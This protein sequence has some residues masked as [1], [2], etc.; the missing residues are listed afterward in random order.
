[1]VS[2][3]LPP[4]TPIQPFYM[5]VIKVKAVVADIEFI[6]IH[7]QPFNFEPLSTTYGG[8][9]LSNYARAVILM[10][11]FAENRPIASP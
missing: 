1:M 9:A 6:A 3:A 11:Q 10:G 7:E 5:L 8:Q 4:Q 2:L